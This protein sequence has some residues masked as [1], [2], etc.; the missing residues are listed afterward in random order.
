MKIRHGMS[1]IEVLVAVSIIG[2]LISL[3]LPAVQNA[4]ET[5]RRTA[6]L[7][8]FRQV[9]IGMHNYHDAH[10]TFPPGAMY[11]NESCGQSGL[12]LGFGWSVM[13]LPYV[14]QN[15]LYDTIDFDLRAVGT[16]TLE[17]FAVGANVI[18]VYTCPS[19]PQQGAWVD[20]C[21]GKKN[22]DLPGED[23]RASS[24][25]GVAD[26]QDRSCN[27]GRFPAPD[28]DGVLFQISRI[29]AADVTDGTSQ[30]L[31]VGEITGGRSINPSEGE[32]Y[33]QTFWMTDNLQDTA[34]GINGPGTVPGLRDQVLDPFDGDGIGDRFSEYF[35][36]AG[37]SSFHP[38]G[39]H[40]L[41]ADGSAQFLSENI[42]A[43]ILRNLTTRSGGDLVSDF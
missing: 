33:A 32:G 35:W 13:L 15:I 9:G 26:S 31:F 37:F 40:F 25:A 23:W 22:G 24:M 17:N 38:G 12:N 28:R 8:N 3:L 30:T 2:V 16:T 29:R 42:S 36:E 20:C 41:K 18:S 6:C 14:E 1:L 21:S 43:E 10:Q 11:W 4:R 27:D 39:C 34:L 7:N 19:D 5:A